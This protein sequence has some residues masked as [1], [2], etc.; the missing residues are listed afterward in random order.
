MRE[1]EFM[2]FS[3]SRFDRQ[4]VEITNEMQKYFNQ[5][6]DKSEVAGFLSGY[7]DDVC[8]NFMGLGGD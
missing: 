7:L 3:E 4:D 8:M 1:C 5:H 6:F 2:D